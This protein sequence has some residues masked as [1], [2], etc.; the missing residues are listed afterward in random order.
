MESRKPLIGLV[1]G[2]Q[3]NPHRYYVN[4]AYIQAVIQGG[5]TP[6]L[7]PYMPTDQ[8]FTVIEQL[9]GIVIPGGI[10]IDPSRFGENPH[11]NCGEIDP[12][13]DELDLTAV[14]FGLERDISMLAICR[15]CQVLNVVL[16]GTLVQDIPSQISDPIKHRQEAPRWFATHDITVQPASI[17]GQIWGAMPQRVNSFHH[18]SI[19]KVGQGLR[20]TAT[21]PDGV[22]EAVESTQHRFVLGIQWHPELMI[23]HYPGARELFRHFIQSA[24]DKNTRT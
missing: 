14:G 12:I 15:G 13:W 11:P 21:A 1:C 17:L 5:G 2:H 4:S 24:A 8:L 9:D 10:D 22:I 18:Q 23:E 16:G 6:I 3:Q 19:R 20:I 7:I